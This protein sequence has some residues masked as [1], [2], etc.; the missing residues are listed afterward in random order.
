MFRLLLLFFT[1]FNFNE[2][3]DTSKKR[4][5]VTCAAFNKLTHILVTGFD[6][7]SFTIHEMPDFNLLN[8]YLLVHICYQSHVLTVYFIYYIMFSLKLN[9]IERVLLKRMN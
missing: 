3:R 5:Y 9:F 6:D 7:G 2:G 4:A 1:R 8:S